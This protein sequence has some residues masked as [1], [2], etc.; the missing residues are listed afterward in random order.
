MN[1]RKK[2]STMDNPEFFALPPHS[3]NHPTVIP[4]VPATTA[5]TEVTVSHGTIESVPSVVP[6]SQS[7]TPQPTTSSHV[8][9]ATPST[10]VTSAEGMQTLS[11]SLLQRGK[12]SVNSVRNGSVVGRDRG[13]SVRSSY[14][15]AS[16]IPNSS[17]IGKSDGAGSSE[18]TIIQARAEQA[19]SL[20][21]AKVKAKGAQAEQQYI[22]EI[23]EKQ[24]EIKRS[25]IELQLEG[26]RIEAEREAEAKKEK[27]CY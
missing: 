15:R 26:R 2:T 17:R 23:K 13:S 27:L 6:V 9:D 22:R 24:L 5:V 14:S 11:P 8:F 25:G 4:L 20:A 21:E 12:A 10:A 3:A 19:R 1:T 16:R 18:E 7:P